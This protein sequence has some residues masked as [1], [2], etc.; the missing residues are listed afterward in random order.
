VDDGPKASI[1]ETVM[2]VRASQAGRREAFDQL[3]RLHQR[4]AMQAAVAVLGT[5]DDAAEAV[6]D[7]FVKAYLSIYGN[8]SGK[9]WPKKKRKTQTRDSSR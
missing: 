4:R 3:V 9:D 1:D 5:A 2:L 6:Q 8:Q 7:A